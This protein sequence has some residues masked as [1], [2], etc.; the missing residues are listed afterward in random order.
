[1]IIDATTPAAPEKHGDYSMQV[2]DSLEAKDWLPK[3]QALMK[4]A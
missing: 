4:H 2:M 1:M 3:L